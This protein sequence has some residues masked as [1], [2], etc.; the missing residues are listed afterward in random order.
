MDRRE[1][2][3]EEQNPSLQREVDDGRARIPSTPSRFWLPESCGRRGA[4]PPHTVG[5]P[6]PRSGQLDGAAR[7]EA[8]ARLRANRPW[9]LSGSASVADVFGRRIRRCWSWIDGMPREHER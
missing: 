2:K 8:R 9:L 7:I 5:H 1:K 4:K 6:P 3:I